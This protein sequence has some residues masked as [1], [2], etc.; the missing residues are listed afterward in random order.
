MQLM[1]LLLQV[2]HSSAV[3][4]VLPITDLFTHDLVVIAVTGDERVARQETVV[5]GHRHGQGETEQTRT[6]SLMTTMGL[7]SLRHYHNHN[8]HPYWRHVELVN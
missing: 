5:C 7:G 6:G 2:S 8:T 4:T 1:T 3:T